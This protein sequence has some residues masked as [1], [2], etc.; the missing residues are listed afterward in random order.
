MDTSFDRVSDGKDEWLTPPAIVQ[1]LGP[2][3]LDPC[4]PVVRPWDTAHTHYTVHDDGLQQPWFGRVWCNPPY[5]N[6]TGKWITKLSQHGDG[7]ALVFG[8]TDTKLFH[9]VVFPR[10]HAILFLKGR[11]TFHHVTGESA[12]Q[13]AGAPSVLIAFGADNVN[14]LLTCPLPGYL[15]RMK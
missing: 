3:D 14:A 13:G 5:G 15:W 7:I 9:D 2:F 6:E 11:L 4:A 10:A 1:A 12:K 8:R